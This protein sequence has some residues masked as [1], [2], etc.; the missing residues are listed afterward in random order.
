MWIYIEQSV[1]VSGIVYVYM[2]FVVRGWSCA[3][4]F[5][6]YGG[7]H[8]VIDNCGPLNYLSDFAEN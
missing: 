8:W 3:V 6:D 7:R 2:R 4:K 5:T 1:M